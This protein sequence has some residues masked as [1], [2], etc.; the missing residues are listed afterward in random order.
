VIEGELYR[1]QEIVVRGKPVLFLRSKPIA[2]DDEGR[3]MLGS[4]AKREHLLNTNGKTKGYKAESQLYFT[5]DAKVI[6]EEKRK[7]RRKERTPNDEKIN[8]NQQF[9]TNDK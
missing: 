5:E 7:K 4:I 3:I 2:F 1:D 6:E 8:D 9:E